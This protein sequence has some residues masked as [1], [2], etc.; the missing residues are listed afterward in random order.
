M[1][2]IALRASR[3]CPTEILSAIVFGSVTSTGSPVLTARTI[4][5][6]AG[7][8]R[9]VQTGYLYHYAFAMIIGLLGMLTF[10]VIL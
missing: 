4:G 2:R 8:L 5:W 6:F 9:H 7:I 1:A 3:G 10:F